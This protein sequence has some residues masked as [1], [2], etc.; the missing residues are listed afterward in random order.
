MYSPQFCGEGEEYYI[1]MVKEADRGSYLISTMNTLLAL[2]SSEW[3][4]EE[5]IQK[6]RKYE[7]ILNR[8]VRGRKY[9][10]TNTENRTFFAGYD[11]MGSVN[12][13]DD[14]TWATEMGLDEAKQI[15]S[16]LES[17]EK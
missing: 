4:R 8:K 13:V 5:M 9:I 17:A 12:W 3:V 16:D 1:H 6:A 10:I 2:G 7:M 15:R 11:S 14:E